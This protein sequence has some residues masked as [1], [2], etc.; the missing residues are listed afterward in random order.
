MFW[1]GRRSGLVCIIKNLQFCTDMLHN[2]IDALIVAC[3]CTVQI[4]SP[5]MSPNRTQ[6]CR[7]GMSHD[8]FENATSNFVVDAKQKQT[9]TYM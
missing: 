7:D 4:K 9:N 2:Y 1:G 8:N 6:G 5:H 3:F